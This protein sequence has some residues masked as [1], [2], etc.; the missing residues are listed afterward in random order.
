MSKKPTASHKETTKL[1]KEHA[2]L[3]RRWQEIEAE[4]GRVLQSMATFASRL[5]VIDAAQ[6]FEDSLKPIDLPALAQKHLAELERLGGCVVGQLEELDRV[7][8]GLQ[9]VL[10]KALE[11][12]RRPRW[13]PS[14]A[15]GRSPMSPCE[16]VTWAAQLTE[17]CV[18]EVWRKRVIVEAVSGLGCGSAEKI[19][20]V[21]RVVGC[22]KDAA[23]LWPLASSESFVD[24]DFLDRALATIELIL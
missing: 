22:A 2:S 16:M 20:E 10:E 4:A 17:M 15:G 6:S 18:L 7:V 11:V 23:G 1:V 5:A 14:I 3:L 19:V 8:E 12:I 13:D 9:R 21:D 24:V